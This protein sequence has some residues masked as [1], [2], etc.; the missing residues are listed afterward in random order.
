M[1]FAATMAESEDDAHCRQESSPHEGA[2]SFGAESSQEDD[3]GLFIPSYLEKALPDDP[4]LQVKMAHAMRAQ[5]WRQGDALPVASQVIFKGTI[6]N[7]REKMG[8][9]PCS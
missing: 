6:E 7:M 8:L 9:G 2:D 3:E 5:K 4:T 1:A